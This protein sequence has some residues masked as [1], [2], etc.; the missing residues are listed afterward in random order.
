M[1]KRI[2]VLFAAIAVPAMAAPGDFGAEPAA[3]PSEAT[4]LEAA[5]AGEPAMPFE[6]PGMSFPGSAF[7]Y[8]A[9]P[10]AE[11][12]VALPNTDPLDRDTDGRELGALI[13]AG[14]AASAFFASGTGISKARAQQCLAQ[15]I[16]YEAASES[17]GGQRAVAQ[18][19]LN[20]VVH[21]SWP[22]SVCGVVYE[23]SSRS[24]GCQFSFT[25]DGSLARKANGSSWKR[26]QQ[27][28]ASALAGDVY[29]PVGHA[30]H[31]HTLW[32]NPYWA[33][34]LEH[35]GT[36]GAH[37]FYRNRGAAG[38]K[39]AFTRAYAGEEPNMRARTAPLSDLSNAPSLPSLA[40]QASDTSHAIG[41]TRVAPATATVVTVEQAP[42]TGA[43]VAD[44]SLSE[45]GQVK[46]PYAN[47]G[48][49][50]TKPSELDLSIDTPPPGAAQ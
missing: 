18:V 33:S 22:G 26:A 27:V 15:A 31:Y 14:P 29:A 17:D 36:I 47:A 35:V 16:W 42:T 34:S 41:P 46:A 37:R 38:R 25:C 23:G 5:F 13:D 39:S 10:P 21:P 3:A 28:A 11:A 43:P 9:D 19:V 32:V 2:A 40:S 48:K 49:W 20:R 4:T 8:L 44:S 24:T 45:V 50:K 30:T 1:R 6:R 12:L 7:Y